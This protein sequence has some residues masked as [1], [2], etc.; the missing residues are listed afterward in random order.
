[1]FDPYRIPVRMPAHTP[2]PPLS[3]TDP[4]LD[5][6]VGEILRRHRETGGP[7]LDSD[8]GVAVLG[9]TYYPPTAGHL[10]IVMELEA[11]GYEVW[12][13]PSMGHIFKLSTAGSYE[14]REHLAR[15]AFGKRVRPIEREIWQRVGLPIYT[16]DILKE[17][18]AR[19][20]PGRPIVAAVGP[21]INHRDWQG[22]PQIMAAGFEFKHVS[23]HP[24]RKRATLVREMIGAG[25]PRSEWEPFVANADVADDIEFYGLFLPHPP[26]RHDLTFL[27]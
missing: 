19:V 24:G 7:N 13:V 22:Y 5:A 6:K 9:G 2:A 20:A 10:D 1:M 11:E 21:D 12:V 26:I 3:I 17:V 18:R 23:E 8:K 16:Y 14:V 27:S 25:A 4:N 15:R